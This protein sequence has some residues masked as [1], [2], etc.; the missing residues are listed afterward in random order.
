VGLSSF[1]DNFLREFEFEFEV[2]AA[3]TWWCLAGRWG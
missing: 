3:F 2:K 1:E